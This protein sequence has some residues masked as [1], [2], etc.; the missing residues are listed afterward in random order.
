MSRS[1]AGAQAYRQYS[2][3]D[4]HSCCAKEEQLETKARASNPLKPQDSLCIG[5]IVENQHYR[6]SS[7]IEFLERYWSKMHVLT[8]GYVQKHVLRFFYQDLFWIKFIFAL[9]LPFLSHQQATDR[10]AQDHPGVIYHH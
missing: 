9:F 1:R 5:P 8:L 4:V 7:G 6:S 10:K 3:Q 2:D